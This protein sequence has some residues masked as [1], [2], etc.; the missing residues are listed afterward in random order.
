[1]LSAARVLVINGGEGG[2]GMRV[3]SELKWRRRDGVSKV[4]KNRKFHLKR[5]WSDHSRL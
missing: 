1:M 3:I 4:F 5:N 2:V